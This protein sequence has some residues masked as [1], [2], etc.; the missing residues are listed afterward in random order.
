M[1]FVRSRTVRNLTIVL[2]TL[3]TA[4]AY[5]LIGS[6]QTPTSTTY[7]SEQFGYQITWPDTWSL[8]TTGSEAGAF[9]MVMLKNGDA[10]AT[11]VITR[12]GD[13][14]LSDIVGFMIDGP[15]SGAPAFVP[16]MTANDGDGNPIEGE[17]AERA[18]LAQNGNLA[19]EDVDG[20]TQFRYG[21]VRRLEGDL[22][23]GLSLAMPATSFDGD[24]APYSALLDG[25]T[26]MGTIASP[27]A[28]RAGSQKNDG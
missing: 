27:V 25:V 26:K 20:F 6:A 14:P 5:P 24:I 12:P 15:D 28:S 3:L 16:G 4:F 13:T 9:D 2:T 19:G 23:V 1:T 22:G 21:E 10:T 17:T 7:V 8:E 11:I 18:W